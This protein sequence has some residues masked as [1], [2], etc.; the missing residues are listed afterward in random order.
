MAIDGIL[1]ID[2]PAG[3]TSFDVVAKIR[4]LLLSEIRRVHESRGYCQD[5]FSIKSTDSTGARP[6]AKRC[7]CRLKVGHSGTLDPFATGLLLIMVGSATKLSDL[8]L[9]KDKTYQATLR[10]GATSSTGDPEGE[11]APGSDRVPSLEEISET[12]VTFTGEILQTPPIFSAIKVNGKRA[13]ELARAGKD[14]EL[15]ARKVTIYDIVNVEYE[16]PELEMTLSVASG[17]YIRSLAIDVGNKLGTG[18]YL[19]SLRRT[20]IDTFSVED[21][22][23]CSADLK[24]EEVLKALKTP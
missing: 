10:L 7:N 20:T 17:T 4:G 24:V 23:K 2:K 16:Y 19:T 22:L 5:S 11:I 3:W 1:L 8:Y 9:K 14:V 13:Y 15:K 21:A 6:L 12:L 18:A